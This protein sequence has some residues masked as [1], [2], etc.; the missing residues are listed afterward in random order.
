MFLSFMLACAELVTLVYVLLQCFLKSR[1]LP[2]SK[3]K[4][5][6]SD[7]QRGKLIDQ[8]YKF[9]TSKGDYILSIYILSLKKMIKIK[10]MQL[11]RVSCF[12]YLY[13]RLLKS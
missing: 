2:L 7:I 13:T 10:Y 3:K 1:G 5:H 12:Y 8:L 11:T 9:I 6:G 4:I